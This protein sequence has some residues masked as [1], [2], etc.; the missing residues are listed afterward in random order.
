MEQH[1]IDCL[2]HHLDY[3]QQQWQLKHILNE[4]CNKSYNL[5]CIADQFNPR[6]YEIVCI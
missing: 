4:H 5:S 1:W 3:R 2:D 6:V